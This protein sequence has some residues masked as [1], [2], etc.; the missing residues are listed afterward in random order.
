MSQADRDLVIRALTDDDS[1]RVLTARTT[2]TCRAAIARQNVSGETARH[3]GDLL[4]GTVL[5]RETMA[6]QLRVQAVVRG[7]GG[8]CTLVADSFPDGGT[9]GLVT[10]KRDQSEITLGGD[11]VLQLMRTMPNGAVHRGVVNVGQKGGVPAA[12]MAYLQ[13]SEQILTM[14]GASTLF[15]DESQVRAAGGYVV[16]LLP[17]ADRE[18]VAV[19]TER[20]ALDFADISRFVAAPE[21]HPD[22]LLE[23]LLY[24]MPFARLETREV[25]F[26]CPCSQAS[27]LAGLATLARSD[28]QSFIDD[29]R[30]LDIACDYCKTE[31]QVAPDQL[32]GLLAES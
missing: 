2:A 27:M 17:G 13:D 4:T 6:P 25:C 24:L 22:A 11:A 14:M 29:G 26:E 15:D 18:V 23:E 5:A 30:V 10:L 8:G 7:H 21:F 12:L 1:F 31:Y 3:F 9:R 16:Q 32:R 20:L 28:I 19:M